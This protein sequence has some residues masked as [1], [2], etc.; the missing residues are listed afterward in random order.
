MPTIVRLSW[1]QTNDCFDIISIDPEFAFWFVDQCQNH[2]SSFATADDPTV[3]D[4][5]I[6]ELKNNIKEINRVLSKLGFAEIPIFENL[7][8]QHNLNATHK[9][10]INVVRQEPKIDRLFYHVG[11]DFFEKFHG[12]NTLVH[13]IESSF[14]YRFL[15][16]PHWRSTNKFQD[17]TPENLLCNVSIN[18]TDWGKSSWH[19]F[20]DGDKTPDDFELSNWQ[21][22]GSDI[23]INLCQ[24]HALEHA[25]DYLDYCDQNHISPA[26][27]KWPLG[28]L[29]DHDRN[30]PNTRESM[31]KNI[32]I[33]NNSL[34]F[35]IVK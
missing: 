19:K 7:Y 24:P 6:L 21:T 35:S 26:V 9:N 4:N 28:N 20:V 2:A 29:V 25:K 30:L 15:G 13:K 18:Y 23:S 33:K 1:T 11:V 34:I 17:S 5:L 16:Q 22:I 10:W 14:N 8:S 12:I 32:Q 31:N 3:I 27:S